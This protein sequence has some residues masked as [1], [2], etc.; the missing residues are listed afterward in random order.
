VESVE[1]N[2]EDDFRAKQEVWW[3]VE[4]K[5]TSGRRFPGESTFQISEETGERGS[6]IKGNPTCRELG[7]GGLTSRAMSYKTTCDGGWVLKGLRRPVGG[8]G[9]LKRP[10]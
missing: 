4:A 7:A 8:G 2:C 6:R 3:G 10:Y 5:K 9:H 1:R